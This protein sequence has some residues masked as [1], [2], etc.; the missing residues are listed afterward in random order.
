MQQRPPSTSLRAAR[1]PCS[2]A[3][4]CCITG[5]SC[6][7]WMTCPRPTLRS[8]RRWM[9]KPPPRGGRP[10]MPN[11]PRSTRRPPHASRRTTPSASSGR[12]RSIAPRAARCLRCIHRPARNSPLNSRP[13]RSC[14]RIAQSCTSG[15]RNDSTP[16]WPQA[17]SRKS[18]RCER[19]TRWTRACRRCA[20]WA[21]GR[22][23]STSKAPSTA[24]RC[25]RRASSRHASSPSASSPGSG[26]CLA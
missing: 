19:A 3:E 18:R 5:R 16:C 11:W 20:A 6:R 10:C 7:A 12:W 17:S 25:A 13:L 22:R 9:P 26:A 4:R 21:T 14:P 1:C 8:A 23:G 24:R 15:S 2:S